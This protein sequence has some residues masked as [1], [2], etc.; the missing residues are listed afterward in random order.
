MG[1]QAY[2]LSL[3]PQFKNIHPVFHVSLLEPYHLRDGQPAP[4]GPISIDGEDEWEIDTIL[5]K[6]V[7]YGKTQYLVHWKGYSPAEDSWEPEKAVQDCEALDKFEAQQ[8]AKEATSQTIVR[9]ESKKAR[10]T[11]T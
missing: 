6:R 2:K 11:K 4:P 8:E 3:P 1:K 10:K 5:A 7:R 9:P